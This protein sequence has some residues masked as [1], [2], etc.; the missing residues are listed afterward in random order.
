MGRPQCPVECS[1]RMWFT[2]YLWLSALRDD[3]VEGSAFRP[4]EES[5]F[6]WILLRG[7]LTLLETDLNFT[8]KLHSGT[9]RDET[10]DPLQWSGDSDGNARSILE[11]SLLPHSAK[12]WEPIHVFTGR[13]TPGIRYPSR[14]TNADIECYVPSLHGLGSAWILRGAYISASVEML[15]HTVCGRPSV[16]LVY[17]IFSRA[18]SRIRRHSY[19]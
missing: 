16:Q 7:I 19:R 2:N 11:S 4:H 18:N 1:S 3:Y 8:W 5:D 17:W 10:E 6:P 14:K 9:N 15:Q 13:R 12:I